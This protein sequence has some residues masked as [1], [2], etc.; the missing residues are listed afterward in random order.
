M[1]TPIPK[2]PPLQAKPRYPYPERSRLHKIVGVTILTLTSPLWVPVWILHLPFRL[3]R[4]RKE[5]KERLARQALRESTP[6]PHPDLELERRRIQAREEQN[7][8]IGRSRRYHDPIEKDP[9]IAKLVRAAGERAHQEVSGGRYE[10]LGTCHL[11]WRRQKEILKEEH[12]IT[13]YSPR[14]M[15]PRVIYD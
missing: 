11:I 2:R 1:R 13:W 15:N 4:E 8:S 7:R 3:F 5:K 14:E 6:P 12:G 10:H 9:E